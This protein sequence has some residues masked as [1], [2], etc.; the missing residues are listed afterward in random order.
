MLGGA[1]TAGMGV[2]LPGS[3]G[4]VYSSMIVAMSSNFYG[5]DS[6]VNKLNFFY[7]DGGKAKV[8]FS[9]QGQGMGP[10]QPQIRLQGIAE[11]PVSRNLSPNLLPGATMTRGVWHRV[12]FLLVANTP[13]L[14]N[15]EAHVWLNGVKIMQHNNI[16]YLA[17]G[18]SAFDKASITSIW[19]GGTNVS[20]PY[21]MFTWWDHAYVSVK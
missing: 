5:H 11:Q 15:G 20:V 16:S 1:G 7:M 21:D 14:A 19:G 17:P 13:G 4:S 3:P 8:Y 6:G 2:V 18:E 12:E 10:L 9:A